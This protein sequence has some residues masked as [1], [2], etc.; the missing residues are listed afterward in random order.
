[1][2]RWML[3]H[4]IREYPSDTYHGMAWNMVAGWV[5]HVLMATYPD[6]WSVAVI[7]HIMD[8]G[9]RAQHSTPAVMY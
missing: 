5:L 3:H 7:S 2:D 8:D 9:H 4:N 6:T 1:M